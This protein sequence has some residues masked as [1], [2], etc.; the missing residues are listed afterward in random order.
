MIQNQ[1][2]RFDIPVNQHI[3]IENKKKE[4]TNYINKC[5]EKGKYHHIMAQHAM[6]WHNTMNMVGT[7]LNAGQA[8]AMTVETVTGVSPNDIAITGAVFAFVSAVASRLKESY[9]FNILSMKHQR[10]AND[11]LDTEK[12]LNLILSDL[13]RTNEYEEKWLHQNIQKFIS[14]EHIAPNQPVRK[15]MFICERSECGERSDVV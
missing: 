14:I 15:C 2:V 10:V 12:I 3:A 5:K 6:G 4:I 8:L 7:V 9:E 13:I 1:M 11:Y